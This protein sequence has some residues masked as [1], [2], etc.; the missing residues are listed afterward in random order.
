[1]AGTRRQRREVMVSVVVAVLNSALT[2]DRCVRSFRSQSFMSKE[3]LVLD[4]GSTDDT[5]G[6]IQ[7]NEDAIAY[8]TSETDTGIYAAWNKGV[9]RARG[10]WIQF[11]GADDFYWNEQSLK[12]V[13]QHLPKAYA[14]GCRV[15]YGPIAR[16]DGHG[17]V[18]DVRG[19]M[20]AVA[21]RRFQYCMSLPHP[22]VLHHRSLFAEHG[23]FD[24]SF[25]VA[26]DY[27]FLL[28]E[29]RSHSAYF[30]DRPIFVGVGLDG[31]SNQPRNRARVTAELARIRTLHSLP[32]PSWHD[33]TLPR[34][35][36]A[37]AA[38]I[39]RLFGESIAFRVRQSFWSVRR[40]VKRFYAR[41]F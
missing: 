5:V 39:S 7:A 41:H 17:Q 32:V 22:A 1:M 28:R 33:G 37:F 2:F 31:V 21:S 9:Q 3:L 18:V 20:W 16:I 8:W 11:I 38:L 36:G 13:A 26:G 24:E 25:K 30:V 6:L 19:D 15:V 10:E 23:L 4:G 34:L 12:E 27:E 29:L 35:R 40:W 14:M